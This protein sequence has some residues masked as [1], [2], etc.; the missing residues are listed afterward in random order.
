MPTS[1]SESTP[2]NVCPHC[3]SSIDIAFT[4]TVTRRTCPHC[5]AAMQAGAIIPWIDVARVDEPG[6]G[7]FL[8]DELVGQ[9]ID[10]RI[11]Q[12]EEFSAVTDRWATMYFIRVPGEQAPRR[13]RV[14]SRS[15]WP[16]T[17]PRTRTAS[18]VSFAFRRWK[19]V[20]RSAFWRPV[21]AGGA[22]RRGQ[23]CA[24]PAASRT[25]TAGGC[26]SRNSLSSAVDRDRPAAGD[27]TCRG[28]PRH[29][30]V[31]DRRRQAWYLDA[32]RDGDGLYDSRQQFHASGA[33]W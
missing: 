23:L 22:G 28:Q 19:P 32:D 24:G 15:I 17:P 20:G 29:R 4:R 14:D 10:A 25:R 26:R 6:R 2:M 11:Y 33:A 13:G 5:G 31:F 8:T 3:A 9:D 16:R 7:G 12:L 18:L 21:V 1:C 27:R 30:L